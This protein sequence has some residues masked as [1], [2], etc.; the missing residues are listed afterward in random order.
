MS[1]RRR[2]IIILLSVSLGSFM[3]YLIYKLRRGGEELTQHDVFS[4]ATN[5]VFSLGII[6]GVG[7]LF[8]WKK[9]NK[10]K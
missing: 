4:L 9:N 5:M 8:L 6:L 10:L 3:S 7:F 1:D 2:I